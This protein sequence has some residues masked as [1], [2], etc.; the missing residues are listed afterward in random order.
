MVT[1]KTKRSDRNA[2][3]KWQPEREAL[4]KI[5][6]HFDLQIRQMQHLRVQ[7]AREDMNPSDY[8]RKIVGLPHRTLDRPRV[9]LSFSNDDLHFLA[10][11]FAVDI[12]DSATIRKRVKQEVDE[13]LSD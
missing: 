3:S 8:V 4:K 13:Y 6:F 1:Q 11:H 10:K 2:E 9:S 7:A 12:D 5:Q